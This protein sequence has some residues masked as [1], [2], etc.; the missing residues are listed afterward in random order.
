LKNRYT[1]IPEKIFISKSS[2][3]E[4]M[5]KNALNQ[6]KKSEVII[7][8]DKEKPE[9]SNYH[10]IEKGK[11]WLFFTKNIGGLLKPCPCTPQ[12]ISCNYFVLNPVLNCNFDCAYC[13]LQLYLNNP[14]ITVNTNFEDFDREV[15][16]FK[17]SY[18]G[19]FLRIG[20]GQWSDSLSMDGFL[21]ISPRLIKKIAAI[22]GTILELK[23]KSNKIESILDYPESPNNVVISWSVNPDKIIKGQEYKTSTLSERINA[24]KKCQDKGYLIGLHFDPLIHYPGWEED[25]SNLI[26]YIFENLEKERIIWISLGSL[27]FAPKLKPIIQSRFPKNSLITGELIPGKDEKLRYFKKIRI[28]LY[29][30]I[31]NEIIRYDK[32]AFIYLCMENKEVWE[33][34]LGS[35]PK[36]S[37]ELIYK[38]DLQINKYLGN[39]ITH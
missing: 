6:F 8:N 12:Y 27:R 39:S 24:A 16:S 30:F 4:E 5:V 28:W 13:F 38:F 20:S 23:T 22:P 29:K 17:N 26:K 2:Y 35:S 34:A 33:K 1:F 37:K 9:Y 19:K 18:P 14:I 25:Y 7:L 21:N 31:F 3:K 32:D 10:P 15:S 11:K 36:S